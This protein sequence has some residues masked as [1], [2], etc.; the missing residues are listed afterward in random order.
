MIAD[1][2]PPQSI[3]RTRCVVGGFDDEE[4]H[5]SYR[6]GGRNEKRQLIE[7]DRLPFGF[8]VGLV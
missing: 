8:C 1:F 2:I 3:L 7:G 4:E 6:E 5:C